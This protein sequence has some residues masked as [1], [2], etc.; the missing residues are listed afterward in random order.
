MKKIMMVVA[1]AMVAGCASTSAT[2]G[3]EEVVRGADGA[4]LVD[5]DG[6]VQ[7]VRQPV[8][9]SAW[10]H[11]FDT[12]ITKARLGVKNGEVDFDLNGYN[13]D[14]SEQ[15]AAWTKE[16]WSGLG[17]IGRLAAATVNPAASG[18][19]LTAE[20]ANGENVSQI[21]KSKNEADVAL[22]KTKNELAIAKLN[23]EALQKSM[24]AFAAAGGKLD[25]ATT[26]CANGS[27]TITDGCVTCKDGV[28][29]RSGN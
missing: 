11:W 16:M 24:T 19:P 9:M 15:F 13:G 18:V 17:V 2:W 25:Q 23:A 27:C 12:E 20:A 22:Q 1:A 14:T 5:K 26:T 3:G 10:R 6:R 28:C 21:I 8:E 7:V 4:P 29:T